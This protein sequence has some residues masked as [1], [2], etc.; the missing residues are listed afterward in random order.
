MIAQ[1]CEKYKEHHSNLTDKLSHSLHV[2]DLITSEE[3]IE[4][5]YEL[6]QQAKQVMSEGVFNLRKCN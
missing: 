6:Y 3:T 1:H 4:G 5:A 2:D